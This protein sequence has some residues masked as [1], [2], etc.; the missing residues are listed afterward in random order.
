M[1]V[2]KGG[3]DTLFAMCDGIVKLKEW[4]KIEKKYQF[5]QLHN[6]KLNP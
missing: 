3:D 1:N 5:T 4:E 2:G 6:E